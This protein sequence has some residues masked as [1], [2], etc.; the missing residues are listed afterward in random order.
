MVSYLEDLLDIGH[1]QLLEESVE[2]GGAGTPV[3]SFT[4]CSVVFLDSVL[5]LVNGLFDSLCPFILKN[6]ERYYI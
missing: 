6:Y 1:C 5:F 2:C 3:L 4:I